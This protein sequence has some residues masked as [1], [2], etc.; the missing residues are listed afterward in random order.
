[1]ISV[2][3]TGGISFCSTYTQKLCNF[4][5]EYFFAIVGICNNLLNIHMSILLNYAGSREKMK[6]PP[7]MQK[8]WDL[9]IL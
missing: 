5:K 8:D 4:L 1:M 7:E 6:N 2:Y 3:V 9:Y